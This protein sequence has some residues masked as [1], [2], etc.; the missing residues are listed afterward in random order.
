MALALALRDGRILV[1]RRPHDAH[2]GGKWEFPGGKVRAGEPPAD[3]ARRE[4]LEETGLRLAAL[5]PLVMLVHDYADRPLRLHV[6]LAPEPSGEVRVDGDREWRWCSTEEL[7][8]L[9]MPEAN[10]AILRALRWRR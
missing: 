8:T 2:Q 9:D 6:F 3:A 4:T 7:E 5:E 10:R 1:A